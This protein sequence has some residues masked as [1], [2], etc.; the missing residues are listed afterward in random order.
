MGDHEIIAAIL[1]AG[2]L[3]TLE[4]PRNR[5]CRAEVA[6][7]VALKSRPHKVQLIMHWAFT[8]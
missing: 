5:V 3:P 7:S 6:G 2:M 1:T 4:I 8:D